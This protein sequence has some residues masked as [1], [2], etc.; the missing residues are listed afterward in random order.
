MKNLKTHILERLKVSTNISTQYTDE[1]DELLISL[2]LDNEN[3][4]Y[5]IYSLTED[6]YILVKTVIKE[7]FNDNVSRGI[8]CYSDEEIKKY[9]IDNDVFRNKIIIDTDD[10]CGKCDTSNVNALFYSHYIDIEES[11]DY[12]TLIIR[13]HTSDDYDFSLYVKAL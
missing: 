12:K 5:E 3:N 7:W 11:I 1:L 9:K 4:A 2:Y 8:Q 13:C 6:N 10:F